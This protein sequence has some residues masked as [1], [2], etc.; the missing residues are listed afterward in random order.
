MSDEDWQ[1]YDSGEWSL[2]EDEQETIQTTLQGFAA[3]SDGDQCL[4]VWRQIQCEEWIAENGVRVDCEMD[5]CLPQP[6]ELHVIRGAVTFGRDGVP[7]RH[8]VVGGYSA[9]VE[10]GWVRIEP[11]C[12]EAY[13]VFR[14]GEY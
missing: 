14:V 8:L 11:Q 4:S 5:L 2:D 6:A 9:P 3:P 10:A 1:D 13:I 7:H 12:G